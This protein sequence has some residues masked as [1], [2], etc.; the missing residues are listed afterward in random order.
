[1]A[2]L[3]ETSVAMEMIIAKMK[4]VTQGS[5]LAIPASASPNQSDNPESCKNTLRKHAHA[6][7]RDFFQL[8]QKMKIPSE[9]F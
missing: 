6:I 3:L 1:M 7:Y 2:V 9:I 4:L 5:P 8:K